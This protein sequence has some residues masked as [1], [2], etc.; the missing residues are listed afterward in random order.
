MKSMAMGAAA[1]GLIVAAVGAAPGAASSPANPI[2]EK[3]R[4]GMVCEQDPPGMLFDAVLGQPCRGMYPFYIFG[5]GPS[6]ELVCRQDGARVGQFTEGVWAPRTQVLFGVQLPGF[7]CPSW[8]P[9]GAAA[10]TTDGRG[11]R[12]QDTSW[13]V[14]S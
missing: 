7:G 11:L 3:V 1:C 12:C 8:L 13:I 4:T 2:C 14:Y 10:Q 6:G 5:R 9:G